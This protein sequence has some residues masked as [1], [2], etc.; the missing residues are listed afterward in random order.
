[1][2]QTL[3]SVFS[4]LWLWWK[5]YVEIFYTA[6]FCL[7]YGCD[8][9]IMLKSFIWQSVWVSYLCIYGVV[10]WIRFSFIKT[11]TQKYTQCLKNDETF[12]R[13]SCT[14]NIPMIFCVCVIHVVHSFFESDRVSSFLNPLPQT[15]ST[16][17]IFPSLLRP[18]LKSHNQ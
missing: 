16:P 8:G 2:P 1:M 14:H 6:K 5:K 4:F 12:L 10:N 13:V 3:L 18:L 9:K 15:R 7:F 11:E 17:S